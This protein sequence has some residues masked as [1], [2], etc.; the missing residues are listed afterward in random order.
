MK[1]SVFIL[2]AVLA[3]A[4]ACQKSETPT[5]D[6]GEKLAAPKI[7]A[8]PD[9]VTIKEIS[10]DH[11]LKIEWSAASEKSNVSYSLLYGVEGSESKILNCGTSLSKSFTAKELDAVRTE[12]G[13]AEATGFTLSVSVE[14]KSSSVL[15]PVQSDAVKINVIYDLPKPNPDPEPEPEPDP[16]PVVN[17]Y[18][19]IGEPFA[20]AWK[21]ADAE[22][23]TTSDQKTYAWSGDAN[24]GGFKI[25]LSNT[26]WSKGYN[27]DKAKDNGVEPTGDEPVWSA[28]LRDETVSK[29]NDDY[30]KFPKDGSYTVTFDSEA[31]TVTV[32]YNGKRS[33]WKPDTNYDM[34]GMYMYGPWGWGLAD[35]KAMTTTDNDSYVYEGE[36][37]KGD[38]FKFMC[39]SGKWWPAFVPDSEDKSKM[40]YHKTA[41]EGDGSWLIDEDGQ[42]RVT[43]VISELSV[44]IE[45]L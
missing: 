5:G 33:D 9:A 43:A 17:H 14:A 12:L 38:L 32:K 44:T 13:I 15:L 25:M 20:W 1:K 29:E 10:D 45:K 39:K 41:D 4:A 11:A 19:G 18:Y 22:E 31:L 28:F 30:F 26:D 16:E 34:D 2:S 27:W 8:T 21:L 3:I 40:V 7:T 35:V 36:L 37:K 24:A 6:D 42:Y 23:F